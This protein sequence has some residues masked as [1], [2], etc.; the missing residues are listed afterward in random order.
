MNTGA[1]K[2][3]WALPSLY[4]KS[5]YQAPSVPMEELYM[6]MTYHLGIDWEILYFK[7]PNK[8]PVT[9]CIINCHFLKKLKANIFNRNMMNMISIS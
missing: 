4:L 7:G 2:F 1:E 3:S 9:I 8:H 6:N 5:Y